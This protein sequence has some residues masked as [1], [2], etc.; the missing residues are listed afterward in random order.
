[1]QLKSAL[2]WVRFPTSGSA[3]GWA[4]AIAATSL[5]LIGPVASETRSK[6]RIAV[7]GDSVADGYWDGVTRLVAR[8]ECLRAHLEVEKFTRDSTGLMRQHSLDWVAELRRIGSRFRPQL[9]VM[10]IGTNDVG[11]DD[12]YSSRITSVLQGAVA[13]DAGLLWIG[14][15]AMRAAVFDRNGREKNK[16][17]EQAIVSFGSKSIKYVQPWT[18]KF[19]SYGPD[20]HG[21]IIQIRT[22]DGT[23][24]TFAGNLL[25]GAYL[26]P[27]IVASP[28]VA[29]LNPCTKNEARAQ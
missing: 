29:Y 18:D 16:L 24:F 19:A 7:V 21:R 4:I 1:M 26:L 11:S 9:F 2:R 17:F 12:S 10:S 22:P 13:S 8:D 23:H 15:P 5:V 25:T 20:E 3:I 14:L 27:K 28:P 6:I